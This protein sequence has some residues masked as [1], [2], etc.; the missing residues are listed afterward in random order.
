VSWLSLLSFPGGE[1]VPAIPIVSNDLAR[2]LVEGG[3]RFY[4]RLVGIQDTEGHGLGI[5]GTSGVPDGS[6][7]TYFQLGHIGEL[8]RGI[9]GELCSLSI[10]LYQ[11]AA[12][13]CIGDP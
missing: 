7:A 13:A 3:Q 1:L 6:L 4:F 2:L 11:G 9:V 10:E 12:F 5:S 8:R